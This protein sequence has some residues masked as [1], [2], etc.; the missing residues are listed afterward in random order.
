MACDYKSHRLC[1]IIAVPVASASGDR[2]V[3]PENAA[4][5]LRNPVRICR[6]PR[7]ESHYLVGGGISDVRMPT[8]SLLPPAC[9]RTASLADP[10]TGAF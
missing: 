7:A 1:R 8:I 9:Q 5:A 6:T 3:C 10:E 4:F 2:P